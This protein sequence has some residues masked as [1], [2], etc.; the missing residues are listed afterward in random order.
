MGDCQTGFHC[1]LSDMPLFDGHIS[2]K[3]R[4]ATGLQC[5]MSSKDK[6]KLQSGVFYNS[7]QGEKI[8]KGC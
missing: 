1:W 8:L 7:T 2:N 3:D 6:N 5:R 4:N